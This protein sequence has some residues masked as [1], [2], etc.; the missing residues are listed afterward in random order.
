M[1]RG[2]DNGAEAVVIG[3]MVL[4]VNATPAAAT[5]RGTTA[6][7]KIRYALGGVARNIAECMS[8]LG[9]KPYM[10]SAV[11]FDLAGNMLLEPWRAAGLSVEGIKRSKDIETA[12]V[13]IIFDGRGEL[14]AA[15]ASVE[16]IEKFVTPEWISNFK[17]NIC[18]APVMMV[19]ANLSRPALLASC[20]IAAECVTPIW[21]EPVSVTKSK[22]IASIAK[23]ITY[24]SPNEDEL[25]AMANAL[26][27]SDRFL[28]V[29]K[30]GKSDRTSIKSLFERLKPAIWVLLEE[31]IKVVLV[32]LGPHG[33]FLCFKAVD[34]IKKHDS[35]K[36]SPFSFSRKLYEVVNVSCPPDRILGT[37]TSKGNYY[38]TVHF[39][40]LPASVVTLV[41]A[42]DCLVG[43]TL[44]SVCAG[45]DIM[46]S[47][48]VGMAAAKGAVETES[49]VP[50][51]YQ[52]AR[53][54][55]DAG[56]IY[57]EAKVIYCESKL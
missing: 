11:G 5:N 45:L 10:I 40:A 56:A 41:G 31:G 44:A 37:P 28:P 15:V 39:P 25:I 26:S 53:I 4:D 7:G 6:P 47:I 24:T 30:D 12:T 8:K 34:G 17:I 54:A 18:S 23:L 33:V 32:T 48:A 9:A 2:L 49:T 36:N 14:A 52:L 16:S 19:D 35:S 57:S 21:F 38:V 51:E 55:D 43:G 20:Q 22:R 1:D 50:V 13:C 46:Q 27:S 3:G 29:Q 42:G